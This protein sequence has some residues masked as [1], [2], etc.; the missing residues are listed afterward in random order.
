MIY[1][2]IAAA[3][4]TTSLGAFFHWRWARPRIL[5]KHNA[6]AEKAILERHAALD[7]IIL[8]RHAQL[9]GLRQKDEAELRRLAVLHAT[10]WE[11]AIREQH[12]HERGHPV[13]YSPNVR[14]DA[15]VHRA[16]TK[17]GLA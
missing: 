15:I 1:L 12:E 7:R 13:P 16:K 9:E 4:A 10:A 3:V 17:L 8:E 6:E 14:H 11:E 2:C 5:A